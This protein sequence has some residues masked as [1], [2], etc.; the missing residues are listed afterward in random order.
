MSSDSQDLCLGIDLGTTSVKICLLDTST[1][2]LVFSTSEPTKANVLDL[3]GGRD[4]QDVSKIID[5][6]HTCLMRVTDARR[7]A[8]RCIA[9]SGQM[10]GVMLWNSDNQTRLDG[11]VPVAIRRSSH[12][13][14][15]QDQRATEE[16]IASLPQP[17][18]HQKLATG[19]RTNRSCRRWQLYYSFPRSCHASEREEQVR[20]LFFF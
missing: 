2:S 19:K 18:S 11:S 5:A 7:A 13:Y 17:D 3:E 16:F 14:T 8:V 6:V 9:V 10:H 1:Q 20:L 4:E 12:L 15:W